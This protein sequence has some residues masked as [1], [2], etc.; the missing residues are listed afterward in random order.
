MFCYA[1]VVTGMPRKA[2][3]GAGTRLIRAHKTRN[4]TNW[5]ETLL[6]M[7]S[8]CYLYVYNRGKLNEQK[9]KPKKMIYK[10]YSKG[11]G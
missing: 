11:M 6:H 8:L 3:F 5:R 1:V 9:P 7:Y 2:G 4:I 10:V